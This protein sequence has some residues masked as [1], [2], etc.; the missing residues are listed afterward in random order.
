MEAE[1]SLQMWANHVE[2]DFGS[3]R[4]RKFAGAAGLAD[5]SRFTDARSGS[6]AVAQGVLRERPVRLTQGSPKAHPN[7]GVK[8]ALLTLQEETR[9]GW[10]ENRCD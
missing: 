4:T 7:L 5:F 8:S 10:K 1:P 3:S 9:S 6:L 2:V